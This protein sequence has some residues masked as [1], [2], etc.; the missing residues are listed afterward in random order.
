MKKCARDSCDIARYF[1]PEQMGDAYF[2]S[3]RY[4]LNERD[5]AIKQIRARTHDRWFW[6]LVVD[7]INE[8]LNRIRINETPLRPAIFARS[9]YSAP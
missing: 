7:D 4:L 8:L 6:R 9:S 3:Y 1:F 5:E 2:K